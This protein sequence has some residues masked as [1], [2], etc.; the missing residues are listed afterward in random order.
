[1]SAVENLGAHLLKRNPSPQDD[2]DYN[3]ADFLVEDPLRAALKRMK[4]TTLP[5]SL[6]VWATLA[7]NAIEAQSNPTPVP[8][9]ANDVVWVDPENVLDQEETGHCVG[10]AGAQWGNTLPVGDH[11]TNDDGHSIYYECKI[12]DK[13]P[14]QEDGT[15]VRS[16]A[17]A[18]QKRGLI[19]TYAFA[20]DVDDMLSFLDTQG[21]VIV[22][23]DWT[24][25]MFN[26]GA[27]GVVRP[28]GGVLGGHCYLAIGH[29][30]STGRIRFLNSWSDGWGV[31]GTFEMAVDDFTALLARDGE[32]LGAVEL[33]GAA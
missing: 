15:N 18:L 30:A 17:K 25:D 6:K 31:N 7:T 16:L 14:K 11:F 13:Q 29:I 27:G 10:F 33:E 19:K 4:Y 26:P 12:I 5:H 9:P 20:K 3:L 24:S 23:T 2:R 28:T 21:P 22:G 1:M 8:N 32:A